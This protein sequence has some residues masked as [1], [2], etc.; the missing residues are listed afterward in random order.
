MSEGVDRWL[1]GS[2]HCV[3]I[4]HQ[5][6]T[7]TVH[8]K[9][10]DDGLVAVAEGFVG[11]VMSDVCGLRQ[12]CKQEEECGECGFHFFSIALLCFDKL[13]ISTHP[14]PPLV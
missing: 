11:R 10:S 4:D 3:D 13:D 5:L 8:F 6:H 1:N 2:A 14:L 7:V 12:G 9:G